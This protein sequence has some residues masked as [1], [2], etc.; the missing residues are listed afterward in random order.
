MEDAVFVDGP[1]VS[2]SCAFYGV[3]DGHGGRAAADFVSKRLVPAIRALAKKS[4]NGNGDGV[5]GGGGL[6]VD[7]IAASL[8]TAY[9]QTDF[10][11]KQSATTEEAS[12][13]TT[14]LVVFV[15]GDALLV[16]N[17]GDCRAVLSHVGKAV[18]LTVDQKPSLASET[19]RI[20]QAGGFVEDGYVNGHLGVSRAFG[21]FH[22]VG[23]KGVGENAE[24]G[25]LVV[26]PEITR[27]TL[28]NGDEFLL[29]ACDGL[30]DVFSSSNAVDFCRRKLRE[31]NS[32]Q[33]AAKEL[34]DEAKKRD[35]ADNVT[36]VVVCFCETFE[37]SG[38][39]VGR[40]GSASGERKSQQSLGAS[41]SSEGLSSLQK[42][43]RSDET[44]AAS[45]ALLSPTLARNVPAGQRRLTRVASINPSSPNRSPDGDGFGGF[46]AFELALSKA[47][48]VDTGGAA[49]EHLSSLTEEG[50]GLGNG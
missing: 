8:K 43:L 23:L 15:C 3:F 39:R 47:R 22:V 20:Q 21:N 26:T 44:A 9:T 7:Y 41:I 13:G 16:A 31:H 40:V 48:A 24:R 33:R 36:A 6:D 49:V 10:E 11:F 19:A 32:P 46:S 1:C 34:C 4:S 18:D 14:A 28:V 27:R 38:E 45:A 2:G 42:A 5:T 25:P 50:G 17:A 37:R 12:S 29:I 30:W 35:T